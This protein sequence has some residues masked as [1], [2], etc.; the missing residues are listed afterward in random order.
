[1]RRRMNILLQIKSFFLLVLISIISIIVLSLLVSIPNGEIGNSIKSAIPKFLMK[2]SNI[3]FNDNSKES[4]KLKVFIT[5]ENEVV[6]MN[7]E[8]Y[9][10]GVV[11]AE[12]PVEFGI[13]ALK[14]QA[15]A[16]R[17]FA[18]AHMEEYGGKKYK[19][20]TGANVCDTVECQV[21]MNKNDRL[22]S[23]P[24]SK[25]E[26]YWNKV[27][28]AVKETSGEV[29]TY[30]GKVIDE[31]LF[32]AVSGG[33]TENGIDVFKDDRPYLK[34]VYSP[35]EERAPKFRSSLKIS[36]LEFIRKISS[37]YSNSGINLLNIKNQVDIKDRN[38]GGSV[39]EIKIGKITISGVKFRSIMGLNSSN[40]NIKF[41]SNNMEIDC[42]GYGHGV[43]MSQWGADAM[44]KQGKNYKEIL[45]HYYSGIEI[46]KIK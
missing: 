20:N 7:L 22:K 32:F 44:A 35:G 45:K 33:K 12:M 9:I 37:E 43:G 14:A 30:N 21:F 46:V 31:P 39:K 13:E 42:T 2:S 5:K 3:I 24:V 18:L 16:A 41:N 28:E 36:Y 40:F 29:L 1:M 10:I 19:S 34:S 26:E 27:T 6:D 25:G 23:W 11:A 4:T 38:E 8:E 17:T 15:V